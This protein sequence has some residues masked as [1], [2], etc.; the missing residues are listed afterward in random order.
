MENSFYIHVSSLIN[1]FMSI[2]K[3]R[4]YTNHHQLEIGLLPSL[5]EVV[6]E[7]QQVANL[8]IYTSNFVLVSKI[9]TPL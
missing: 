8:K 4:I 7:T 6:C 3:Q 9:V 5:Y 1:T 2:H